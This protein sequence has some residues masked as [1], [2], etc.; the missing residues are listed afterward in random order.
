MVQVGNETLAGM[1]W[2]DGGR[3]AQWQNCDLLLAGI[4]GVTKDVWVGQAA[5]DHEIHIDKGG[6]Q[7]A[8][9]S[10]LPTCCNTM[11]RS[12]CLATFIRGGTEPEDLKATSVCMEHLP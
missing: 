8:T 6:N 11:C 7:A 12:T 4:H 2:P 3:F 9:K 5:I 10:F 1:M